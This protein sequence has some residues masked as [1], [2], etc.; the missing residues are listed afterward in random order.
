VGS[1]PSRRANYNSKS[2]LSTNSPVAGALS[3]SIHVGLA[4]PTHRLRLLT[5]CGYAGCAGIIVLCFFNIRT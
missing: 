4:C 1:N 5:C 3:V 2:V